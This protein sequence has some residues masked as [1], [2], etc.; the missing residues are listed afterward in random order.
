M[1]ILKSDDDLN[2][3]GKTRVVIGRTLCST[4][5]LIMSFSISQVFAADVM[6]RHVNGYTPTD[7][8]VHTFNTLLI[9]DGKVLAAG[10]ES[11]LQA[12]AHHA[13]L[14]DAKGATMLPGL[15]DAHGHVSGWGKQQFEA[16][17]RGFKS[18]AQTLAV[19]KNFAQKHK[20]EKWLIARGWNQVLWPENRFP[21]A[22]DLDPL[23]TRPMFLSRVDGHAAWVNSK[24][25]RLAGIDKTTADP[26]GG[27]IIRDETGNATG[28]LIDNAM[29]LVLQKMPAPD[30]KD[31][32][33]YLSVGMKSLLSQGLTGAHDAG[34]S[35]GEF[36]QYEA[37]GRAG[38]LPMRIYAMLGADTS[39]YQSSLQQGPRTHLFNDK[40]D[41]RAIKI[42]ADG[43]LGSRG[44]ALNDDYSD[45]PDTKGFL[46]YPKEQLFKL[47]N[48]ANRL[49]WQV[50]IHAIGDYANH[51]VLD[52]YAAAYQQID[53]RALRH[54]IEHA[55]IVELNDIPRF[56]D[57]GIIASMQPTH[58]TSDMNM[59]ET[60]IGAKRLEGAYAWR[61]MLS[62]GVKI[63][64]GS[65][66]PVELANPFLGLYAAISRKDID[67]QPEQGW[68]A[69]EAMS[70]EEAL[71][72]FTLDAAYAAHM[73]DRVGS[74]SPG[75]WADF[76]LIDR[77][78]FDVPERDIARTRVLQTWVAGVRAF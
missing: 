22:R 29:N 43:A 52:A 54:R 25:L 40:L 13:T 17:L 67:G 9:R 62:A 57:L 14:I 30:E 28:V 27:K 37:L 75:K 71:R 4:C 19:V 38:K 74:L 73:E 68:H 6:I 32:Q 1:R 78:Y 76:I 7:H 64:G 26:I 69:E 15:I 48:D 60:R 16:D 12:Q 2:F 77:D 55:Q 23:D 72:A 42:I 41:W 39:G 70:R 65:D 33:R 24:A 11:D 63:A 35:A 51:V 31:L 56:A 5:W 66:F 20:A 46:I 3:I 21:D 45:A 34:I 50:N 61:K 36:A 49:G 53:G 58:A 47:V 59:A 10:D 44:A 18:K 8:D